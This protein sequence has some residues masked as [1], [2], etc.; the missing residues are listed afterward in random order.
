M[1]RGGGGV[2]NAVGST[3]K[4]CLGLNL[5]QTDWSRLVILSN[6]LNAGHIHPNI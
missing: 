4:L 3:F 6:A 5:N 1:L 2:R